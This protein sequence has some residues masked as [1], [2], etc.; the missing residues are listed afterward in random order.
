MSSRQLYSRRFGEPARQEIHVLRRQRG[1]VLL[2]PED[3][4][5]TDHLLPVDRTNLAL[6]HAHARRHPAVAPDRDPDEVL[7]KGRRLLRGV[8]EDCARI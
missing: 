3:F 4:E 6:A 2:L 1:D 8:P 7:A 5:G